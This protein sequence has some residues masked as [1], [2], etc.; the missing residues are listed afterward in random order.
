MMHVYQ[1]FNNCLF[2]DDNFWIFFSK[3]CD[4]GCVAN[5]QLY[6]CAHFVWWALFRNLDTAFYLI[7]INY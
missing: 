2:T 4:N 6:L 3:F 7:Q 5:S 1:R